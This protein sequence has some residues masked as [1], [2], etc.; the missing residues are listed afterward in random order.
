MCK[1]ILNHNH[2]QRLFLFVKIFNLAPTHFQFAFDATGS[3][4]RMS[5]MKPN[6]GAGGGGGGWVYM[7]YKSFNVRKSIIEEAMLI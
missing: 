4:D 5:Q 2:N 3:D 7:T 1:V 6:K